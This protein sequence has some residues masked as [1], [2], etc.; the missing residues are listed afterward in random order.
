MKFMG[1]IESIL[2]S[3][4]IDAATRFIFWF[5]PLQNDANK[6]INRAAQQKAMD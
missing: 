2:F 4:F 1:I 5:T 6:K 3:A